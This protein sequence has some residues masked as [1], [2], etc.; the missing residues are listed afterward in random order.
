MSLFSPLSNYDSFSHERD[1]YIT[2]YYIILGPKAWA[3]I[4]V[5]FMEEI[6]ASP[7]V[8]QFVLIIK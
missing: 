2:Q 5:T 1:I 4:V 8:K 6:I 7:F 3:C